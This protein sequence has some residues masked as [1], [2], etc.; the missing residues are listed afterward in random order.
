MSV[1]RKVKVDVAKAYG[2]LTAPDQIRT[3]ER[4]C[5]AMLNLV[6]ALGGGEPRLDR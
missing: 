2:A 4:A 5:E 6:A 3:S 1:K